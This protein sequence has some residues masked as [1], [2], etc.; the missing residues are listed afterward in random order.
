M[1]HAMIA[2]HVAFRNHTLYQC[3]FLF[4]I[5]SGQ[6]EDGRNLLFPE[7]VQNLRSIAVFIALVKCQNHPASIRCGG[8]G[9]VLP[10]LCVKRERIHR[11]VFAVCGSSLPIADHLAANGLRRHCSRQ[12][13]GTQRRCRQSGYP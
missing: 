3:G 13:S 6:K 8:I 2:Q 10:I 1:C 4:G 7:R 11:P 12:T 5:V 9:T